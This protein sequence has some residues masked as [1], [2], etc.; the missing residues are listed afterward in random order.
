MLISVRNRHINLSR[1]WR[2]KKEKGKQYIDSTIHS[3]KMYLQRYFFLDS[4]NVHLTGI[5]MHI[6]CF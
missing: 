5:N 4:K 1:P 6:I 3:I 2:A